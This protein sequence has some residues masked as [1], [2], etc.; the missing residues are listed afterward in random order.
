MKMEIEFNRLEG[1]I[2]V[3]KEVA[4][5]GEERDIDYRLL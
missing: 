3:M 5:W 1:A 4:E 2:A